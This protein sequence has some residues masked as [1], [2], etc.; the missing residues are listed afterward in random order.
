MLE[1]VDDSA[2]KGKSRLQAIRDLA[3][4]DSGHGLD[5]WARQASELLD[6]P[7][8]AVSLIDDEWQVLAS[9]AGVEVPP[10]AAWPAKQSICQRVITAGEPLGFDLR[11]TPELVPEIVAAL[12]LASYL[13]VPVRWREEVVGTL[14]VLDDRP[15]EWSARE[16]SALRA[17]GEAVEAQLAA[18]GERRGAQRLKEVI[19]AHHRVHALMAQDAPLTEVLVAMTTA[20]EAQTDGMM[21]SILLLDAEGRHLW[22][23]AAPSLP[24]AY[25]QALNGIE[26]G[27]CVGSCGT[28]AYLKRA[29][30]A[31]DVQL[32]PFWAG[33]RSLAVEH[34]LRSCWSVPIFDGSREVLGTFALYYVEPRTPTPGEFELIGQASRLAGIAIERHRAHEQLVQLATVDPLTGLP[35]RSLL[36][37]RLH[38]LLSRPQ[39]EE[40]QSVAVLFCD[41]DRF[42]LVN[43]SLGHDAGDALLVAV[44][45][46]LKAI[47]R[48]QDIVARLGGDE[49]VIVA[50]DL[51]EQQAGN[52]AERILAALSAP[53]TKAQV[54]VEGVSASIG[55][56][57]AV[58]ELEDQ[59]E[60]LIRRA[61][62]AMYE[63]KRS[64]ATHAFYNA[65][66][67][68]RARQELQIETA[69][70]G[71]LT[72]NEFSVLFQPVLHG[73]TDVPLGCETL[74]RWTNPELGSVSPSDFVPIAEDSGLMRSIGQWV[75]R[76]ACEQAVTW[77]RA[78]GPADPFK[79]SV[80]VSP[81]QLTDPKF[82][83][84][85]EET[86]RETAMTPEWL[87]IEITETALMSRDQTTV[88]NVVALTKLGC[89]VG[90]DDFGTGYSSLSHLRELPITFVKIDRSFTADVGT[91]DEATAIVSAISDLAHVLG[92]KVVAEGVET[93]IQADALKTIGCDLLQGYLFARPGTSDAV[94]RMLALGIPGGSRRSSDMV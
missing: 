7:V 79:V 11:P 70:R 94:S 42:K 55:I 17:V 57:V 10:G 60:D 88:D 33:H 66:L 2:L 6:A 51:D 61:D 3:L 83:R 45:N 35:N 84:E 92:M 39:S 16:L 87:F 18:H 52:L 90:L 71:A 91:N 40:P 49:F 13:G 80:N 50:E 53:L 68:T 67:S 28:A 48:P 31:S 23:A 24:E 89:S 69:L 5:S 81:R 43:D 63:A 75:L 36:L 25:S 46:R 29:V 59:A 76:Q 44:A 9:V 22:H 93:Q 30:F 1:A 56:A 54:G 47:V 74:L 27:P 65:H 85:V 82:S 34:G 38:R 15:R 37:K 20:I 19:D 77:N 12:G 73:E 26:I 4:P 62:I 64:R 8:A 72:R 21:A 14:C 32:D 86:I 41:I 58:T 78:S